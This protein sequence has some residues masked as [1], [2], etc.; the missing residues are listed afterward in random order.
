MRDTTHTPHRPHSR[1]MTRRAFVAAAATAGAGLV[2]PTRIKAGAIG[3]GG[4]VR[5][6]ERIILGGIGL[7]RRGTSD[8]RWMLNERDV[9]FVGGLDQIALFVINPDA[10]DSASPSDRDAS[11]RSLSLTVSPACRLAIL[12]YGIFKKNS[13]SLETRRVRV[14]YVVQNDRLSL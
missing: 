7:G 5:P 14:T 9:Q 12:G 3:R 4:V 1:T 13:R 6:S 11:G 10:C 2:L 8:L